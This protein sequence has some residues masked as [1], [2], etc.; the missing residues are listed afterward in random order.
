MRALTVLHSSRE[1]LLSR[2][3]TE[4]DDS[5]QLQ[6]CPVPGTTSFKTLSFTTNFKIR[7]KAKESRQ[8]RLLWVRL[9]KR[10]SRARLD[11]SEALIEEIL[12]THWSVN[13]FTVSY[14]G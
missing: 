14:R 2:V 3:Y 1:K 4:N 5:L 13:K 8:L 12:P 10:W 6:L 11:V 9:R 7:I